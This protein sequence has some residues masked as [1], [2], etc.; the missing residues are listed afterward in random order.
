MFR[1]CRDCL[2]S[3]NNSAVS[4][5]FLVKWSKLDM[6][7]FSCTGHKTLH[8][9]HEKCE[10][11]ASVWHLIIFSAIFLPRYSRAVSCASRPQTSTLWFTCIFLYS[12]HTQERQKKAPGFSEVSPTTHWIQCSSRNL[13]FTGSS[14]FCR[15]PKTDVL[16]CGFHLAH[17]AP[18]LNNKYQ[19]HR[20]E[21]K[22]T[23]NSNIQHSPNVRSPEHQ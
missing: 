20:Q 18:F 23:N 11:L 1:Q 16:T 19:F 2:C 8:H 5:G 3:H 14:L 17:A 12:L 13:Y 10:L 22:P 9:R 4:F 15:R 6:E 7:L 21:K